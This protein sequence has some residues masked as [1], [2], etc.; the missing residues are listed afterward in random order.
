[1]SSVPVTLHHVMSPYNHRHKYKK[2]YEDKED[3]DNLNMAPGYWAIEQRHALESHYTPGK[4]TEEMTR[5]DTREDLIL[6][7]RCKWEAT[8]R[9]WQP[10]HAGTRL[11]DSQARRRYRAPLSQ[12]R[13]EPTENSS[14][15][16]PPTP[17]R[18]QRRRTSALK[19]RH[20]TFC[21]NATTTPTSPIL[22]TVHRES[23]A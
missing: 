17:W 6:G 9:S 16:R 15:Q 3:E 12:R 22:A 4:T 21:Y 10:W 23:Q 2:G 13:R 14:A 8:V 11:Q 5:S 19:Q 18:P 7:I 1:M 20:R